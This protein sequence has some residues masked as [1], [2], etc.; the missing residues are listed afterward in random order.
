MRP[1]KGLIF[2]WIAILFSIV[3]GLFWYN[4]YI[5]S[6]PTPVPESY[7]LV[8]NDEKISIARKLNLDPAKPIALHFFNP[9]CPCSRF[10]LTHFRELVKKYADDVSFVAVP[11]IMLG[12]EYTDEQIQ[13]KLGVNIPIWREAGVAEACGVYSTPQSVVLKTDFS[14]YYRGNYNKSRYCTDKRSNYAELAITSLVNHSARPEF[15]VMALTSYGCTIE[16]C[17]K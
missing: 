5:Y 1:G 11:M 9:D 4:E 3:G 2:V 12:Q 7:R 14:L 16:G 6:L 13:E 17:I 10:N 15:G 8:N